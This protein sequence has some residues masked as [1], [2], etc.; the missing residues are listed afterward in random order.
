LGNAGREIH[1]QLWRRRCA[2]A[3]HLPVTFHE[4][5]FL[6]G[7]HKQG[8]D[9][10]TL[11]GRAG[12]ALQG[13]FPC[14]ENYFQAGLLRGKAYDVFYLVIAA[15]EISNFGPRKFGLKII[16]RLQEGNL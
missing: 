11:L 12:L 10:P 14:S 4:G 15:G 9:L 8:N 5:A 6:N 16:F 3:P 7:W 13:F 1:E 2:R